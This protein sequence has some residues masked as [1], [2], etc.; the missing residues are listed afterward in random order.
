MNKM[1]HILL[2][3]SLLTAFYVSAQIGIGTNSPSASAALDVYGTT[4]GF[5]SPRVTL[6]TDLSSPSP[7]V[8]PTAGLIVFNIG[9]NQAQGFY[10]WTGSSWKMIKSPA[11]EDL[12]GAV[13]ST[14]NAIVRF[15]GTTG[16]IIQNSVI[17]TSDAGNITGANRVTTN[18]FRLT[19]SPNV[20]LQLVSDVSG[21]G[22]WQGAP[23]I[24]VKYENA[25]VVA[26]ANVL[27]F[28]N[29]IN[30]Q[31]MGGNKAQ[32]T[33]YK[34]NVTRNLMQLSASDTI[35]INV[36][37]PGVSIPW[38]IE[39]YKDAATFIHS[40]TTNPSRIYVLTSGIYEINFMFSAQNKTVK[41]QTLK[42]QLR[43]N[44]TYIFPNVTSYSFTYQYMDNKISHIS[45]SF[46]IQLAANDYIELICNRQTNDGEMRL[47]AGENVFF[48]RLM[49][50]L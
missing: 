16:K 46:L 9:A 20:G 27:N 3:Y 5:L 44:G 14:D 17:L 25:M 8:S 31:N 4:K 40:N 1:K 32:I 28:N 22:T 33:F 35:D 38:K 7:V 39:D 29:G 10:Y 36:P 2:I 42:A 50:E 24:D 23:P 6:S 37:S 34:N 15:D 30:V 45:S 26:N 18:S 49:R 43:K 12:V 21:N 19:T 11:A 13:S 47:A 41:R 48:I